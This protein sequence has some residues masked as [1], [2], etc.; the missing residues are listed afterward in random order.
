M[1]NQR[2]AL[3]GDIESFTA[4]HGMAIG[5]PSADAAHASGEEP[6]TA[7][8]IPRDNAVWVTECAWCKRMRNV[9][10]EWHTLLPSMSTTTGIELT[11]GICPP[12]ARA[13]AERAASV[14][15][16]TR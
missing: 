5:E 15:G 2:D 1:C 8:G 3:E 4:G 9:A 7:F 13:V 6:V 11:H 16:T 10:G 12:C 14:D